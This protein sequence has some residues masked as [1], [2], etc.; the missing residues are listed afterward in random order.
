M[1]R[2]NPQQR[3]NIYQVIREVSLIRGTDIP[4]KDV[5]TSIL[6]VNI[7]ANSARYIPTGRNPRLEGTNNY[8]TLSLKSLRHL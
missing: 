3:P 8:L 6:L 1:L 7:I 4:I 5:S 2:E